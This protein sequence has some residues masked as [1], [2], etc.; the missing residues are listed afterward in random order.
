MLRRVLRHT[1]CNP[2]TLIMAIVLPGVIL[3]LLNYGFGGA[4]RTSGGRYIDYLVP[5]II[6]MG[7]CY[8]A[9]ATAVAVAPLRAPAAPSGAGAPR[10]RP[11]WPLA[12]PFSCSGASS[13]FKFL[14]FKFFCSFN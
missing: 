14:L 1:T 7:A 3:L 2:S 12:P 9:S 4:I 8:S 6:L 10:P 5:G 13:S 11:Y